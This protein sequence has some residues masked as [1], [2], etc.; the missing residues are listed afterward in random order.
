MAEEQ[1]PPIKKKLPIK[2][3]AAARILLIMAAIVS[4]I[5][6]GLFLLGAASGHED[7]TPYA[8][9]PL[10]IGFGIGALYFI[11]GILLLKTRNIWL[12]VVAVI[13]IS[14]GVLIPFGVLLRNLFDFLHWDLPPQ[15][16]VGPYEAICLVFIISFIVPL[17]LVL[18]DKV[19][20]KFIIPIPVI[21]VLIALGCY[22]DV[23]ARAGYHHDL[24]ADFDNR[25]YTELQDLYG[26][27]I[28]KGDV[29][30][31]QGCEEV[32]QYFYE[33]WNQADPYVRNESLYDISNSVG[34]RS[35]FKAIAAVT[36]NISVCDCLETID[37]GQYDECKRLVQALVA[38]DV[39]LCSGDFGCTC[40]FAIMTD[41]PSSCNQ[42]QYSVS[43][44]HNWYNESQGDP[45]NYL[46]LFWSPSPHY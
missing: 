28:E 20:F 45:D 21:L 19:P 30:G 38:D 3:K 7:I 22:F 29:E 16:L 40:V 5:G 4:V 2:T 15:Y 1:I 43:N 39:S 41:S 18:L 31:C 36:E 34:Y 33:Q 23:F 46:G 37:S 10:L 26:E 17:I 8:P 42:L 32:N 9:F 44:C 11:P 27:A 13:I 6:F 14:V 25:M 12:W 24:V 35:C